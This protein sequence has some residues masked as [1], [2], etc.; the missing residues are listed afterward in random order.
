MA[1]GE[2]YT[3]TYTTMTI[4]QFG[5]SNTKGF[6]GGGNYGW[7]IVAGQSNCTMIKVCHSSRFVMMEMKMETTVAWLCLILNRFYLN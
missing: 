4:N 7:L 1:E 6:G 3:Y 2:S 5:T